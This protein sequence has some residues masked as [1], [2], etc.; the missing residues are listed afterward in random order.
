MQF[1]RQCDQW[2]ITF[3]TLPTAYWHEL[4]SAF[5]ENQQALPAALRMVVIGGERALPD[6]VA[7]WFQ[8]V[9]GRRL[10]PL[11]EHPDGRSGKRHP[12]G[13]RFPGSSTPTA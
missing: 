7:R 6:R 1:L 12:S 10:S 4:V 11:R 8:C 2:G 13:T 3:L 5:E 9:D